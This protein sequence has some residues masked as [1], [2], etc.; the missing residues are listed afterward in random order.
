MQFLSQ[1]S[2]LVIFAVTVCIILIMLDSTYPVASRFYITNTND[3]IESIPADSIWNSMRKDFQLD[4]MSTSPRVQAEINKLVADQEK[5]YSI[6]KAA[7]PYIYYIY[8]QTQKKNLPAEIALIPV[9]ESEFNPNDHSNKGATGLWQ[10][11]PG[12]A[13]ELGVKVM[14]GYDG[15][16]NVLDSTNAALAYFKDLGNYFENDWYLAIAA[17][18]C[19]QGRVDSVARNTGTHD[20]WDMLKLPSE[21]K[22]YVPKLLA[23][24]AIVK[25][26]KKYG[27]TLPKIVNKPYFEKVEAKKPVDLKRVA[28]ASGINM[29]TLTTL[30]PDYNHGAAPAKSKKSEKPTYSVLVPVNQ[31]KVVSTQ[32]AS[33]ATATTTVTTRVNSEAVTTVAANT[34]TPLTAVTSEKIATEIKKTVKIKTVMHHVAKKKTKHRARRR[35][36]AA[37][38]ETNN[39]SLFGALNPHNAATA[40]APL[41]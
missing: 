41:F 33:P 10:L 30:N 11:M 40:R 4:H 31:A 2:K 37:R 20:F 21:T 7:G 9:I 23:V 14:S 1:L 35:H 38:E 25:N 39:S 12:T 28:E 29:K 19:G 18:N 15:R 3:N 27:V 22:H 13:R 17:Y 5:L 8:H 34:V 36:Y 16:R 24:A 6:L 32:L 26:P